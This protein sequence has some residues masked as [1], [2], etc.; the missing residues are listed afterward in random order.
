MMNKKGAEL[1][2]NVVIVII[3]ALLV[4]LVVAI[5]FL[6]GTG[7]LAERIKSFFTRTTNANTLPNAQ[8][9]CRNYCNLAQD[10]ENAEFS[11]YCNVDYDIDTNGDGKL[12]ENIDYL[13]VRCGSIPISVSCAGVSCVYDG[14]KCGN[15]VKG[16]CEKVFTV[17]A[18]TD[19][20]VDKGAI[21]CQ[22]GYTCAVS[23][24]SN[25]K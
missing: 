25:N 6:G 23:K 16:T 2:I 24:V 19:T 5:I 3:I 17:L 7:S 9:E 11:A 22:N 21:D 4:L 15:D 10:L 20:Y 12:Q 8:A 1:S 14:K 13:S 18:D